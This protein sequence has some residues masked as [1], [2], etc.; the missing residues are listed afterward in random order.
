MY[1]NFWYPAERSERLTDKPLHVR[2]LA[3]DLVLFRDAAG[4]A[5]CLANTC[6]HRGGSLSGGTIR[7]G[8]VQCPYH[9]WQFGGDGRCAKIPSL[10]SGGKVPRAPGWIPTRWRSA[11]A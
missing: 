3:Q 2:M 7:D 9:G 6:V 4:K 11:T 10:G 8:N 1:I 5:H